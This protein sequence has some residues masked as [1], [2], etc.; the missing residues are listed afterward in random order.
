VARALQNGPLDDSSISREEETMAPIHRIAVLSALSLAL[1]SCGGGSGDRD[2][3]VPNVKPDFIKGNIITT[4]YDGTSDD[5]LTAGLGK[6]GLGSATPPVPANPAS[7]TAAELRKI[8]I[9]NNYRALVDIAAAGG[10]GTLYGPNVDANGTVTTSEGKIAGEED[11]AYADDGTGR[12]NVT[13]MVQIPSTFDVNNP[14]IVT[15]TSSGSR[16]VY[17]AIGTAGEWGLKHGCAVAYTDKGSGNGAHD[18]AANA[19][20]LIQGQ[21]TPAGTAGTNSEFTANLSAADLAA[22]NAAFPNRWAYKHAHSQQNPEKDWGRDTLRAVQFAFYMLNE[23]FGTP[24]GSQK[25][26]TITRDKTIVIASSV[27]NGAGASVAALEQDTEDLIDGMAVAEPQINLNPPS[28]L[29]IMRGTRTVPSFAHPLLDYF[30][31]A[32]LYQPCASLAPAAAGSPGTGFVPAAIATNRCASL[33]AKGLVAG[34][35]VTVQAND[36]LSRLLSAGWELDS[37]PFQASHYALATLSVALTYANAFT[38]SSVKDNLCGYSFG[39]T[40]ANGVPGPL[41]AAAAAQIFGTGNGVPPTSGINILNNNSVGGTALDAASISP[42]TQLAD[43][44]IDGAICLRNLWTG[45]DALAAKARANV[46][47]TKRTGNLHGKP[48]IIVHGRSDTLVP[49]NNTSRPYY[50]LNK[51]VDSGSQLVYYEVTNAQHFDAFIDNGALPGYDS[52]LVPLHRYFIQ[53]M[54]L[55]YANLKT[56]APLPPS[57]VVRTTPRGGEPG[58]APAIT[59]SNVPAISASPSQANQITFSNNTLTIPD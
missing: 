46:D 7:P 11:I 5:L 58:K 37:V 6:T 34:D 36:S 49:V 27:S 59:A 17:G 25:L 21:R 38:Q 53:A 16:G 52:R 31:I 50:A 22:F 29:T 56:G 15:A 23:K 9:Y 35:N 14:C 57:Q 20:N 45:T 47:A 42:S 2:I 40:P 43:F 48:A 4:N 51:T 24:N 28:N 13:M 18:L 8:A 26:Q 41:S 1:A 39:G 32:N 54:D 44:N 30:T 19:V 33:A 12:Q 10:Y 55:M 3:A